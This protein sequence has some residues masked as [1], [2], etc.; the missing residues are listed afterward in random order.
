MIKP[1]ENISA[2]VKAIS[3]LSWIARDPLDGYGFDAYELQEVTH[4]LIQAL[5]DE[6]KDI[7]F[8][9]AQAIPHIDPSKSNETL[10][11]LVEFLLKDPDSDIRF[12]AAYSIGL[13]GQQAEVV[14]PDLLQALKDPVAVVRICAARAICE[15]G[16]PDQKLID[17]FTEMLFDENLSCRREAAASLGKF[18]S[19]SI[20]S[21][22]A[23]LDSL[24]SLQD[25]EQELTH[26]CVIDALG[27][28]GHASPEVVQTLITTLNDERYSIS[29]ESAAI[30]LGKLGPKAVSAVPDLVKVRDEA[31]IDS[32]LS[33]ETSMEIEFE[34]RLGLE[35]A[36]ALEQI[37]LKNFNRALDESNTKAQ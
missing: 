4:A 15:I 17:V 2:R 30:S 19:Q 10:P 1:T 18:G 5:N 22:P 31:K 16:I 14:C 21:L 32:K 8:T 37:D 24:K 35:A 25:V 26:S 36:I 33:S 9:A 12:N 3:M 6:N 27:E 29:R 7:R 34:N 28:I 11:V 13:F 20:S 23:L